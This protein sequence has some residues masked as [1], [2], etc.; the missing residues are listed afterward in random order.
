MFFTSAITSILPYIL[1]LGIM[2]TYYLGIFSKEVTSGENNQID[3]T[4][5]FSLLN[6]APNTFEKDY[7]L[8]FGGVDFCSDR[9]YFYGLKTST[10]IT[11]PENIK[12]RTD[13]DVYLNLFSRPPP[14]TTF[15]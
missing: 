6:E 7:H 4:T 12:Q 3:I 9:Q 11:F 10:K 8:S 14:Y 13:E 1:F 2:C 15:F 5:E